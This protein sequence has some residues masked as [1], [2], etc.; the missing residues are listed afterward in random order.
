MNRLDEIIPFL[1][2]KKE[3][4][5]KIVVIQLNVLVKRLADRHITLKW[6][7]PVTLSLAEAGYDPY[8]GA[9]PLKRLIQQ[10]IVNM[11]SNALLEGK[12]PGDSTVTLEHSKKGYSFS[13]T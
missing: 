3:D 4:M 7:H 5:E 9:R 2:L 8:Y 11:L 1:P 13:V 10:E 12:I 6:T